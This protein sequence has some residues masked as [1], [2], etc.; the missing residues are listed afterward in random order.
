MFIHSIIIFHDFKLVGIKEAEVVS[1]NDIEKK[2]SIENTGAEARSEVIEDRKVE[3][4]RVIL[5]TVQNIVLGAEIVYGLKAVNV[6]I[7]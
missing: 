5:K 6:I 2:I 1:T 3:V 4:L 7:G